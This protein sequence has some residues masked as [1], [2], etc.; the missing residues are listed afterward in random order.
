MDRPEPHLG[1]GRDRLSRYYDFLEMGPAPESR[2][3]MKTG[4]LPNRQLGPVFSDA[5]RRTEWAEIT[6]FRKKA[7][8]ACM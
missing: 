1:P 7:D 2:E 5:S 3:K 6:W 8:S 4:P